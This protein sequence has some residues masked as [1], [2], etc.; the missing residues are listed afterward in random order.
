MS[1]TIPTCPTDCTYTLPVVEADICNPD[2]DFGQIDTIYLAARNAA[3]FT[4]WTSQTEW[5]TRLSNN[6]SGADDIRYLFGIGD[7]PEPE[8]AE[9]DISKD[10]TIYGK[11]THTINFKIEETS[12][13][14]YTFMRN[15]ECNGVYKMWYQSSKWLYGGSDGVED[16]SIK[17][18]EII[19]ESNEEFKYINMAV[20]WKYQFSPEKT[21]LNPI[22]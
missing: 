11:K 8:Q 10:R 9:F 18:S 17:V 22:E 4:D 5:N 21:E 12:L 16:V 6:G 1:V 19:P 14:N 15:L 20:T 13:V 2:V 3:D 7:K